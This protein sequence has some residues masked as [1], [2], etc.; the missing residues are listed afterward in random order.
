MQIPS[1]T[2][3]TTNII[4]NNL[5]YLNAP[6]TTAGNLVEELNRSEAAS[7]I[8]NA[9]PNSNLVE[10]IKIVGK[11]SNEA[12]NQSVISKFNNYLF[13]IYLF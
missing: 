10:E 3:N 11:N 1:V 8:K 12:Y 4:I 9:D 6:G 5:T 7:V 2:N 13:F